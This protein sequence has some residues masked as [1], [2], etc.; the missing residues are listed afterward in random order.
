MSLRRGRGFPDCHYITVFSRSGGSGDR[1]ARQDLAHVGPTTPKN[2]ARVLG[3]SVDPTEA[4]NERAAE[5]PAATWRRQADR[6]G[7]LRRID[8]AGGVQTVNGPCLPRNRM[9]YAV[10]LLDVG[11]TCRASSTAGLE[12]APQGRRHPPR[13]TSSASDPL[14]RL[15]DVSQ[16]A[17]RSRSVHRPPPLSRKTRIA[18]AP[19]DPDMAGL[20]RDGWLIGSRRPVLHGSHA[21][22]VPVFLLSSP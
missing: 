5:A 11:A 7:H 4:R 22:R 1:A 12:I 17:S 8:Y 13:C 19:G 14:A 3:A 15:D 10:R 2:R 9:T 18:S 16:A 6:N 21:R 20:G